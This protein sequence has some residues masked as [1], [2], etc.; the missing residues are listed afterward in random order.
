MGKLEKKVA[1]ITGAGSGIGKAAAKKFADE[2][3]LVVVQDFNKASAEEVSSSLP[4]P[5]HF[6]LGGDVS[7]EQEMEDVFSEVETR[8]ERLD[9]LVNNAGVSG[10][11]EG[12][13]SIT[14]ESFMRMLAVNMGGTFICT[15]AALPLMNSGGSIV[16]LS[17]IAGLAGW[18]PVH[19]ASAKGAILGFTRASAR[20][21][22]SL[23]IRINAVA[24]GVVETPM[25]EDL[26][27]ALLAPLIMMS[28]LGRIG[29]ADEIAAAI[30]Y[31]ACDDSSFVTGQWISPNGGLVTI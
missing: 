25:T 26:D 20:E 5:G 8:C 29:Q 23:G 10:S 11:P 27:E 6:A 12:L 16:N 7:K 2:G 19:Y 15:R 21:L 17:S 4:G 3:A 18:G 30:L 13:G 14:Y 31:L 9:V 1:L 28:P 24:P 22:G